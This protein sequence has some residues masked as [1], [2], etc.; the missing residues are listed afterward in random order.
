MTIGMD[1][2]TG[3]VLGIFAFL[4]SSGGIMYIGET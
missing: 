1:S 3:G 4:I 2:T